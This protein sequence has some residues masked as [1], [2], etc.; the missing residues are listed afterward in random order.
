M[1]DSAPAYWSGR[2]GEMLR[3][4]G[5]WKGGEA[6]RDGASVGRRAAPILVNMEISR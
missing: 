4:S 6:G 5:E 1:D 2:G 3:I